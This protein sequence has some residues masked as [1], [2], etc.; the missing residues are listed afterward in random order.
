MTRSTICVDSSDRDEFNKLRLDYQ[1][2][3]GKPVNQLTFFK[4][5]KDAYKV[6]QD[7]SK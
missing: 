3:Q 6:M 5:I 2:K 7:G 1:G 4:I